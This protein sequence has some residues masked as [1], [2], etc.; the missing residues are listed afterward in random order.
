MPDA[1]GPSEGADGAGIGGPTDRQEPGTDAAFRW[2]AHCRIQ[3]HDILRV[4]DAAGLTEGAGVGGP[5]ECQDGRSTD[6]T[7]APPG[8]YDCTMYCVC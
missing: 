7:L 3:L 2:A 5:T 8:E 4:L 6:V 1:A